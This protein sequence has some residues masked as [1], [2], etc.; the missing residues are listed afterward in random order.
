MPRTTLSS[1]PRLA[2]LRARGG[3]TTLEKLNDA[4]EVREL[5]RSSLENPNILR[6]NLEECIPSLPDER[7]NYRGILKH[8][9]LVME[10]RGISEQPRR[11]T[12]I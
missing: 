4:A 3:V 5:A 12:A 7:S 6:I 8:R 2:Y 10:K 9:K 11:K 1:N